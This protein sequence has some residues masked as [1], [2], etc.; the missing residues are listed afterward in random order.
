MMATPKGIAL[1][2]FE[3][4]VVLTGAGI[5]AES[6]IP[7]FRGNGG[8]W[9]SHRPE[10]LATLSAF[11]RD[12]ALVWEFYNWRRKLIA[13][14]SPNPGH[15][16]LAQMENEF[17]DF[18]IITQNVDGLHQRAGSKH[19]IEIH[20]SIWDIKCTSCDQ[21][22]T[23]REV[24]E[25]FA[26]PRC[27]ICGEMMRPGVVWFGEMLQ[28]QKVREATELS[29]QAKTMLVIG[30]SSLIQP[31][32]TLPLIAKNKGAKLI[33]INPDHTPL[34]PIMDIRLSGPSGE[35]LPRWWRDLQGNSLNS[36]EHLPLM[37]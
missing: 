32:N 13:S 33:E 17:S 23:E 28:P 8:I 29:S 9:R 21:V 34:S 35:M 22:R 27:E 16:T 4:V 3:P 36:N 31:A 11:N 15:R 19:V 5:S 30:T 37:P 12:P 24:S 7:T 14:C 2:D 26:I 10:D 25:Y 20:G 6:G 1:A 18:T